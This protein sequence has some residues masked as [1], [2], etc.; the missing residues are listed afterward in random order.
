MTPIIWPRPLLLGF[1]FLVHHHFICKNVST[2]FINIFLHIFFLTLELAL[3]HSFF[4]FFFCNIL[5][6]TV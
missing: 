2:G 1:C 4:F 5:L 3:C 6:V